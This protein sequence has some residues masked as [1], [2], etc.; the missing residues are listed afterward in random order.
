M[1]RTII[2]A[3]AALGC[4]LAGAV[5]FSLADHVSFWLACYWAAGTATTS[6]SGVEPATAA[7]RGVAVAVELTAIPLLGATFASLTALHVHRHVLAARADNGPH[8]VKR[9]KRALRE[10]EAERR[11]GSAQG[12]AQ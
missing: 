8:A 1:K 3:A 4:V 2:L 7:A 5:A 6:G 10:H 12:G 9:Q 11:Q